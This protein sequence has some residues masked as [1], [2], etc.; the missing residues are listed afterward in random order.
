MNWSSQ[1]IEMHF[2][3]I[4]SMTDKM[5]SLSE[6]L[7]GIGEETVPDA[8]CAVKRGW[9]SESGQRLMERELKLGVQIREEAERLS[10]LSEEVQK[11]AEEMYRAEQANSQLA[12]VRVY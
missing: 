10:R 11:Q 7:K 1:A 2:Q 3:E 8:V 5:K 4:R 12:S 9:S 6:S